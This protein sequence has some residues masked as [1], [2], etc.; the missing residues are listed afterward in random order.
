MLQSDINTLERHEH[1][2]QLLQRSGE[3]VNFNTDAQNELLN[4]YRSNVDANY[5]YNRGCGE[6]VKE[7]LNKVYLWYKTFSTQGQQ[8]I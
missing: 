2:H 1:Y 7:F 8:G 4:V 3:L 6:C 5:H